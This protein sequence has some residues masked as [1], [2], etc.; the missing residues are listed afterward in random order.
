MET[1]KLQCFSDKLRRV[2]I[3]EALP[4][5]QTLFKSIHQMSSNASNKESKCC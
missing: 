4:G 5:K 2:E 1:P 3:C